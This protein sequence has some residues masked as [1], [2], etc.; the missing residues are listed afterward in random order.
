M[1]GKDARTIKVGGCVIGLVPVIENSLLLSRLEW[2]GASF[3]VVIAS[4]LVVLALIAVVS[5]KQ[6]PK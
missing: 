2:K 6:P 5:A 1:I 4:F 3:V